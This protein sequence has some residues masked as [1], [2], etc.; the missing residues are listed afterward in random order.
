MLLQNNFE[1]EKWGNNWNESEWKMTPNGLKVT[2]KAG[3]LYIPPGRIIGSTKS[4]NLLLPVT[5]CWK[6]FWLKKTSAESGHCIF[7]PLIY[8]SEIENLWRR[9]YIRPSWWSRTIEWCGNGHKRTPQGK[10]LWNKLIPCVDY[11]FD[12]TYLLT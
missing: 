4:H 1:I 9:K 11:V 2:H 7:S 10:F 6:V 3:C 5:T 12:F 8:I